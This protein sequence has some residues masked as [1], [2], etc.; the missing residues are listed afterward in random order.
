M[1]LERLR[2]QQTPSGFTWEVI[3]SDNNSLDETAAVVHSYQQTWPSQTPLRYC[4][5]A[6]QGAA[7]ARQRAVEAAQG[8]IIA[9]LDDDNLP[10]ADWLEQVYQFAQ[11][12][13]QAGA[14]G[15]QIHGD[16]EGPVP[17]GFEK[18]ACYL[19]IVERGAQAHRYEPR[20]KILPPA[21]GLAVRRRAWLEAVPQKL[22]LNH[23]GKAAGLAS[24]DLEALLYIQKAGWDIWHNPKMVVTHHIPSSR[25]HRE[26]LLSLFRCI[27][28]SRFYIRILGAQ[29]WQRHWIIPGYIANDWRKLALHYIQHP[30][31]QSNLTLLAACQRKHLLSTVA[32]PLF[33]LKKWS[34]DAVQ[35]YLDRRQLPLRDQVLDHLTAAVERGSIGLYQQQIFSLTSEPVAQTRHELLLRLIDFPQQTLITPDVFLPV[36]AR[37]RLMVN[38]DRL[39]ISQLLADLNIR[40]QSCHPGSQPDVPHTYF[41]NLSTASVCQPEFIDFLKSQ[42]SGTVVA[43][44]HLCFEIAEATALS[45]PEQ[46]LT[47]ALALQA[48]GCLLALEN[49]KLKPSLQNLLPSLP[50]AYLKLNP[51]AIGAAMNSS[52]AFERIASQ[53]D[54]AHDRGGLCIATGIETM[55]TLE[56]VKQLGIPYAQGFLLAKPGPFEPPFAGDGANPGMRSVHR[57]SGHG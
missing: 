49:A 19:A 26:Y 23:K 46:T 24:E 40:H 15:S 5:A 4:F 32:S 33:L 14:M 20:R 36:A 11:A 28:L 31:P 38:L 2:S 39:V 3:V 9:F 18:I 54:Q 44:H 37:Y 25:L 45:Y 6:E 17:D 7:C 42:L 21:A 50:I 30:G 41:I 29:D 12:H 55:A 35:A 16:Y 56:M 51:Q 27:G 48:L 8:Q 47:F 13:P 1:V 22:F 34:Q 10:A 52:S 53:V 43:P 57:I